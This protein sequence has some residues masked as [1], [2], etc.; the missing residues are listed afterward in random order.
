MNAES[1]AG[2]R[3]RAAGKSDRSAIACIIDGCANLNREEKDC[4]LELFDIYL[5][6]KA[7]RDYFYMVAEIGAKAVGF[8]CYGPASLADRVADIYWVLVSPDARRTGAARRLVEVV[9]EKLVSDGC[10]MMVAETSGTDAYT[11]AR[12]FY[13]AC[14]FEEA[15]RL[16][17]FFRDNDDKVFF[18]KDIRRKA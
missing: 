17:D 10:R 4:A 13:E 16:K 9:E 11:A 7:Q 15:A 2:C 3:I 1:A 14:G 8:I 18:V 5:N 6:D 12:K